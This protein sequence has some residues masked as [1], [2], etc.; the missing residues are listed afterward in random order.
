[1][2]R[3]KSLNLPVLTGRIILYGIVIAGAVTILVPVAW[4]ISTS[5]KTYSHALSWPPRWIPSPVSWKGYTSIL[6]LAGFPRCILNTTIY[7]VIGAIVYVF[8]CSMAGL[9]FAKYTFPGRDRI[10]F[11][12][13]ATLMVP[14]HVTLIPIFLFMRAW[15]WIN[16][17]YG[18]I[19]PGL[20]DAFGV[21]LIRQFAKSVPTELIEAARLDGCS[22]FR[23][24]WQIFLPLSKPALATLA[25]LSFMGR[26]NDLFWPLIIT[27]TESMR[28]LQLALT[29]AGR[30]LY[31]AY[32]NQVM[33]GSILASIPIVVLFAF[34][35]RSFIQG[36]ALSGLKG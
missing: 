12:L 22:E 8:L 27:N 23:I 25:I 31:D 29:I 28:T 35:Q 17:F 33:A 15:G 20:A 10:F 26:W 3:Y 11:L 13:L 1:M 14:F 4:M 9:A 30:S 16:T 24:Y 19:V 21:F 34:L 2:K 6:F 36:I 5:F 18:L 32:W 7:A